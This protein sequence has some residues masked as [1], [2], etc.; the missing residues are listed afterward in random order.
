MG[1]NWE[2]ISLAHEPEDLI[3]S[4]GP[5]PERNDLSFESLKRIDALCIRFET[6]LK[7]GK[8]PKREEYLVLSEEKEQAVLEQELSK[9]EEYY[10]RGTNQQKTTKKQDSDDCQIDIGIGFEVTQS[11][12]DRT[13]NIQT[14]FP[15]IPGYR[16]VNEL[17]KGASGTVFKA[18]QLALNREVAIKVFNRLVHSDY[19]ERSVAEKEAEKLA[20]LNHSNIVRIFDFGEYRDYSYF[21]MELVEGGD[22]RKKLKAK[23]FP[24]R[25]A[26]EVIETISQALQ[27]AHQEG[28]AHRDLKPANILLT[29]EGEPKIADFG[30][31]KWTEMGQ[32]ATMTGMIKGTPNYMAPEQA[33]GENSKVTSRT[34]VWAL[35]VILY[36]M[37]TRQ[38]PFSGKDT[39]EIFT[40]IKSKAPASLRSLCSEIDYSL[41]AIVL[42][43]LEK[44][45]LWRYKTSGDLAVDL[46]CWLEGK[47]LPSRADS[48]L[49]KVGRF[50][51]FNRIKLLASIGLLAV[52]LTSWI[53]IT[54]TS[55]AYVAK[56]L[57]DS[58]AAGR[59]VTL[60]PETGSSVLSKWRTSG[61][62]AKYETL[63]DGTFRIHSTIGLSL[64]EL[65]PDPGLDSYRFRAQMRHDH[66]E[67]QGGIGLY[68]G[69]QEIKTPEGIV[70]LFVQ[71]TFNDVR[72]E[73]EGLP[74]EMRKLPEAR[75][76]NPVFFKPRIWSDPNYGAEW[77]LFGTGPDPDLV[78]VSGIRGDRWRDLT[79]EVRASDIRA[80]W[81]KV[82]PVGDPFRRIEIDKAFIEM[83]ETRLKAKPNAKSLLALE[84]KFNPK[85]GLGIY[86]REGSVAVRNV[87]V[88]PLN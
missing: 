53:G 64:L 12:G 60:I 87:V 58:L 72:S 52:V 1:S 57:A 73:S 18:I 30:L 10:L 27:E 14:G 84:A 38:L 34:D 65:L 25:S 9:L 21:S 4:T 75:K 79:I 41:E 86:V 59:P 5:Q 44:D 66:S 3:V 69:H 68:F 51:H 33:R 24:I 28:L 48:R 82:I 19:E 26:V 63:R 85:G 37:L 56:Q 71:L 13:T 88:E 54:L 7:E 16:I 17:G 49:R 32:T 35:G 23:P 45:P 83:K 76:R 78:E 42:K 39:Q 80:Y 55:S 8:R 43:C 62:G 11:E 77:D 36:E 50:I 61:E 47:L 31:A 15:T 40:E 6:E 67:I 70:H 74:E 22:L 2:N 29:N 46:R 81:E 20:K